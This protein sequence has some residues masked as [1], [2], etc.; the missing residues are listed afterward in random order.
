MAELGAQS[1]FESVDQ[2]DVHRFGGAEKLGIKRQAD[3]APFGG[4]GFFAPGAGVHTHERYLRI[5]WLNAS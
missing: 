5:W 3:S 2:I 4:F 1:F